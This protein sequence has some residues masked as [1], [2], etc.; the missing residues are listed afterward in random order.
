[1]VNHNVRI[2]FAVR[3]SDGI[4][5]GIW[6][7]SV[8]STY[9]NVLE[10]DNDQANE[11]VGYAQAIQGTFLA[12]AAIP[13]GWL[14]IKYR[15]DS[16]LKVMGL[17]AFAAIA[18]TSAALLLHGPYKYGLL[19]CGLALWGV[20]QANAPVLDALFADSVP[21]GNR[22]RLYTWL[23]MSYIVSQG[24][25]PGI[26][27]VMF[28]LNGNVWKLE[29][30]QRVMLVG[31]LL[32]AVPALLLL[33]LDD[34]QAL[35]AESEGLLR[36]ALLQGEEAAAQE[37]EEARGC[38]G[39]GGGGGAS[40][41]EGDYRRPFLDGWSSDV[42]FDFRNQ[43]STGCS[44]ARPVLPLLAAAVTPEE[45]AHHPH[46]HH[47]HPSNDNNSGYVPPAPVSSSAAAVAP[48][49]AVT[50]SPTAAAAGAGAAALHGATGAAASPDTAASA[51]DAAASPGGQGGEGLLLAPNIS[52]H[53]LLFS[54]SVSPTTEWS[55]RTTPSGMSPP[56]GAMS[57]MAAAA[58]ALT[59]AAAAGAATA[60]GSD[61]GNNNNGHGGNSGSNVVGAAAAK[62][63]QSSSLQ[64]QQT[65][66]QQG[67]QQQQQ[68]TSAAATAA[69]A[70][71]PS[72]DPAAAA[73]PA[74]PAAAASS[75]APPAT[76][77]Q[78][79]SAGDNADT[80]SL[81]R[82]VSIGGGEVP[83][84]AATAG[85]A[86]A[87]S[88]AAAAA[89]TPAA[90]PSNPA[91]VVAADG[92]GV[93][94]EGSAG[95]LR[96]GGGGS[97]RASAGGSAG[98]SGHG[99]TGGGDGGDSSQPQ[100]VSGSLPSELSFS[101]LLAPGSF[102]SA[103]SRAFSRTASS[104]STGSGRGGGGAV[105]SLGAVAGCLTVAATSP[106]RGLLPY[107]EEDPAAAADADV[108]EGPSA[109]SLE[110]L[111][112]EEDS[113]PRLQPPMAAPPSVAVTCCA[114]GSGNS[115][116]GGGGLTGLPAP[117][118]LPPLCRTGSGRLAVHIPNGCGDGGGASPVAHAHAASRA[119]MAAAA[120]SPETPTGSRPLAQRCSTAAPHPQQQQQQPSAGAC[121]AAATAAAVWVTPGRGGGGG[122]PVDDPPPLLSPVNGGSSS[123]IYS[124]RFLCLNAAWIPGVLALTDCVM[125]LASGMTI[126][127]FP[128]FFKDAVRLP[129]TY[130]NLMYCAI[131]LCL[132]SASFLAQRQSR[133]LGRVQ[134]MVLNRGVGIGLLCWIA[135]NPQRWTDPRVMVPVYIARTSIMNSIYPLQK[136]ILM[137][138]VPKERRAAWNSLESITAFGWS[139]SAALGG[140]LIHRF[141]FQATFLITA[142]MQCMGWA[143]S[144]LLLPI[145]PRREAGLRVLVAGKKTAV[146]PA[147]RSNGGDDVS[148][149][150]RLSPPRGRHDVAGGG[151]A[152]S[153]CGKYGSNGRQSTT[154]VRRVISVR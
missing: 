57:A 13:A 120:G 146:S 128:I 94:A 130:V 44:P 134:T 24:L 86:I 144:M 104:S 17:L 123:D 145:V 47:H 81:S 55:G 26:G 97:G 151:T 150:G 48:G 30:L 12:V 45:D 8:L 15:R 22:S 27:A 40:P 20:A 29:V 67:E 131:P 132:S 111:P 76:A 78:A 153:P 127:F 149:E 126:K 98:G 135:F 121:G 93:A 6:A 133:L 21:T 18:T 148:S 114:Y 38:C 64:Q 37:D 36:T 107:P 54:P 110:P 139:G 122:G 7:S 35:G 129:P 91:A 49:A 28:A 51:A 5:T 73:A 31:M 41:P 112:A 119:C 80:D 60:A 50:A 79:P 77:L 70:A 138:F 74:L 136:S 9:I 68:A 115:D 103:Y 23:H 4:A 147:A 32:A 58:A 16:I 90:S 102:K 65:H 117:P 83:A 137:D 87:A 42:E 82:N 66:Q 10:G 43:M 95:S 142:A 85:Y 39:G 124:R 92:M 33:C 14:A 109:A 2:T 106:P 25:G 100:S 71:A 11:K 108:S 141:G 105:G 154:S 89:A 34:D 152:G 75:S 69:A 1:M 63:W 118:A 52:S 3:I 84:V 116:G 53:A 96:G 113:P 99:S 56:T 125:G 143:L 61:D 140:W 46:H 19:C 101:S 72:S 62:L 59:A 88:V